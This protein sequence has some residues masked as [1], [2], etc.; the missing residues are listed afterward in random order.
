MPRTNH[1]KTVIQWRNTQTLS[2][3]HNRYRVSVD[4][5]ICA[6]LSCAA[7]T[8]FSSSASATARQA[9]ARAMASSTSYVSNEN[10]RLLEPL[11][12]R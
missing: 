12:R 6:P 10:K 8:G 9:A 2:Q 11:E 5:F 1:A 7:Q 3:L 4:L